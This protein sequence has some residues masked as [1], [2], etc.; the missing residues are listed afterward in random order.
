MRT[1]SIKP[2]L[3]RLGLALC[4][5][6]AACLSA[7]PT[8]AQEP[9]LRLPEYRRVK[10]ENGLTLLLLERHQ[11]PLVSLHWVLKSGGAIADP[12]GREGLASLT[13]GLLRKGTKTR[14]A[15]QIA[16]ALDFVG[17]T[18]DAGAGL[19]ATGGSCECVKKDLDAILDLM[20]DMLL[21]P[22][23][24]RDELAKLIKQQVDGIKEAKSVPEEVIGRYYSGAMFG[25]HPYGRPVGGT[26][27]SLAR[28]TRKDVVRFYE[29][30]YAPNELI[31]AVVGDFSSAELEAKVRAAL[32]GWKAKPVPVT[33]LAAPAAVQGRHAL[34]V[35]KPDATQTFFEFGN[36]GLAF[37][38]ADRVPVEVVNTLFGGR[39]T[40]MIN[41]ELRIQS[42]LT[43]GAKSQFSPL[44]VPGPFVISSYTPNETT[45]RAMTLALETLQRLH[46][47]GITAD[48]LK[49]AKAYLKGAFP[50]R[51][52]TNDQL[53]VT[54]AELELYGVDRGFIDS[55][56]A[57]IDAMTLDDARRVI[58]RYF[59]REHLDFVFIG[60][61]AVIEPV[62]RKLAGDV[63]RKSI[64]QP[65]F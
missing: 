34:I 23:F 36:F 24:P 39:F 47:Q 2:L 57:Q 62:A 31:L 20:A 58:T 5:L 61:A 32:G 1:L 55:W 44:R 17:A 33:V 26:E 9:T 45:D 41:S 49:S 16:E 10:L 54:V 8:S 38:N 13:A 37:T 42:G 53:A 12:A 29:E 11:L 4:A 48:Q 19:D 27:T 22:A 50:T 35:D 46:D 6:A 52:E 30:R 63:R 51:F 40:S 21:Q 15:A 60:Q 64:E 28:M 59:P 65:G 14:N 18:C 43:Y 25:A 56:F 3:S 7:V